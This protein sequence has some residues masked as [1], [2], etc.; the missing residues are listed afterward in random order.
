MQKGNWQLY[1]LIMTNEHEQLA[2][3]YL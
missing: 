2:S 1:E 3:D